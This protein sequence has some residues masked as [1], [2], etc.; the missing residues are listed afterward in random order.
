MIMSVKMTNT[1]RALNE[2]YTKCINKIKDLEMDGESLL[3]DIEADPTDEN[4][5]QWLS[6]IKNDLINEYQVK[7]KLLEEMAELDL[8]D[9]D[10]K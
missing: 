4:N 5:Y 2:Q 7:T 8:Y 9:V 6:L 10:Y 3:N 1:H